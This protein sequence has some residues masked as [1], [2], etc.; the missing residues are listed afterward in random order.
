MIRLVLT[1]LD[2]TLIPSGAARASDRAIR[3]VHRLI[4][5]GVRFGPMSGRMPAS[6]GWMFAGDDL[7]YATGGFSNGLLVRIDGRMA[8]T[9]TM[10]KD[11]LQQVAD[12]L[13]ELDVDC[14]L[15][16]YDPHVEER[17]TIITRHAGRARQVLPADAYLHPF[18]VAPTIEGTDCVKGNVRCADS[19]SREEMARVRDLLRRRIKG[20]SFVFPSMVAPYIDLAP[21]GWGKGEAVRYMAD[22]LGISLEEVAVFGDSEND[23][24]M[25]EAVPNSVVVSNADEAVA[26]AARWHIGASA[27]DAVAAA[28]E[29][30]A[31]ASAVGELP[32]WMR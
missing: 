9:V 31:A 3:A 18:E 5:A 1:D 20:L 16:V 12:T 28:M 15:A 10:G 23:L 7:C 26:Q 2:D 4:D 11:M 27:D 24:G 25:L 21:T 29:D 30:I 17:V 32:V 19:L 13:D 6:M 22:S 8:H 14:W